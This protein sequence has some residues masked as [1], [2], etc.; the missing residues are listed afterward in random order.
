MCGI[1][2][3]AGP[4]ARSLAERVREARDLMIDR[5]PDDAGLWTDDAACLGSRRLAILDLSPS[6]HMPMVSPDGRHVLV[7]N[8]AIYNFVELREELSRLIEFRSTGDTEVILNGFRVWGWERLLDRLDGMFAFALWDAVERTLYAARDRVGEKPFFYARHDGGLSFAS[9]LTAL[10]RLRGGTPSVDVRALDAYLTYQAVPAPLAIFEG[11]AQLPPAHALRFRADSNDLRVAR[12]WDLPFA[13]KQHVTE[14][15][16]I[17]TIDSLVRRSVAQR[18]RS[19]VPTGTLLSGGVDSSLITAVASQEAGRAIDAVTM[20]FHEADFDERPHARAVA[21]RYGAML[22]EEV[23]TPGLVGDLPA[24]VSQYG[25]PLADVSIVPNFYM[26]RAARR[27]MTVALVGDGADEAF[28]GYARPMVMRA[29]S[30]YRELVP[31]AARRLLDDAFGGRPGAVR[32]GT[33]RRNLSMLAR[34]GRG[35]A[36]ESFVYDRGL[37]AIRGSA[38]SGAFLESLGAWHPDSLYQDAWTRAVASDDTD[39]ALYGDIVTYLPD[40]LLAKADTSAMAHGLEA[41]SPFLAREILEYSATLPTSLRLRHHTTKY[42][43]KRVAE[44]YVPRSALY[45]RKRGFVMP[46]ADWL[47]GELAPYTVALLDSPRAHDRGWLSPD[48]VRRLIAEHVSGRRDWSQ[49][50]WTLIVL[51][52]WAR[53]ALDASVASTDSLDVVL[54]GSAR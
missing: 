47:R 5:G 31:A 13:P 24:I 25:Q 40:Q 32:T 6:G 33:L 12:Y 17:D 39:R 16:A 18:L 46:A 10:T 7:F 27:T 30:T 45:R 2:G 52:L 4:R 50:L 38:Y 37:R 41:R 19:D 11:S 1:I 8:G 29:A 35:T 49:Q 22:H 48:A 15:E 26:A 43:L 44:R 42:L 34:A 21:A 36:A 3:H 51:E 54:A 20:G 23:L 53:V 9:T 14:A 28:G